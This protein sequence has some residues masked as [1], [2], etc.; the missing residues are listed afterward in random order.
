MQPSS[1]DRDTPFQGDIHRLRGV[2]ILLIVATH[3]VT[4][5]SWGK[6]QTAFDLAHDLFDNSTLIFMFI[7][8]YLFHHTSAHFQYTRYL[9]GKVR[10]VLVP[11]LIAAAPGI[12]YVLL[13]DGAKLHAL[14]LDG[15]PN[16]EKAGYLLMYGGAQLNYALWFIPVITLYYLVSPLLLRVFER[17][18]GY[19][20][21]LLLIPLS[22]LMHRPTYNHG[23]NVALALY[24]LSAYAIG[25]LCSKYHDRVVDMLDRH[26]AT[27]VAVSVLAIVGHFFVSTHHGNYSAASIDA[28]D[29]KDGWIDWLFIQKVVLTFALW[30][31][32][33]RFSA[34]RLRVLD[35][36]ASASFTI[37]FLHLYVLF[38][39]ASVAHSAGVEIDAVSFCALLALAVALPVALAA[40]VRKLAPRWSRTLVGS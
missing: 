20:L 7:S 15:R 6:H 18:N 14:G 31:V 39:V 22:A 21:L 34:L 30:A 19:V 12:L 26:V 5:F 4:F 33:R 32:L 24:F 9:K 8:G 3:C 2:A 36:L 23:H 17:R 1:P 27:L 40:M 16:V 28:F 37:Y 25:M 29:H 38:I 13:F 10:N 35:T 11:Y